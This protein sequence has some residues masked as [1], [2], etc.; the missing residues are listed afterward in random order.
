MDPFL[1][2]VFLFFVL[3][4]ILLNGGGL[5][6]ILFWLAVVAGL[7][8]LFHHFSLSNRVV[9]PVGGRRTHALL[10]ALTALLC[11]A[12]ICWKIYYVY[13]KHVAV[14]CFFP[15]HLFRAVCFV[16]VRPDFGQLDTGRAGRRAY[17]SHGLISPFGAGRD[18][19]VVQSSVYQKTSGNVALPAQVWV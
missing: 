19:L 11:S 14:V 15:H 13:S 6:A 1:P 10:A 8:L 18:V 4:F 2:S 7:S 17:C 9:V 5:S 16:V 12:L 3:C